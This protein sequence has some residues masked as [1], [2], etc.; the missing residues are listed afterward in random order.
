MREYRVP[1]GLAHL[2]NR[3]G[4]NSL[5]HA[6]AAGLEFLPA[7]GRSIWFANA[8]PIVFAASAGIAGLRRLLS[9]DTTGPGP[10]RSRRLCSRCSRSL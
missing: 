4:F 6:A 5:F 1:F 8:L 2:H 10:M 7:A 9:G 3:L